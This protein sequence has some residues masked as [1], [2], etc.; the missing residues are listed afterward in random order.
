MA[1]LKHININSLFS[2]FRILGVGDPANALWACTGL[3]RLWGCVSMCTVFANVYV[4][5]CATC[6]GPCRALLLKGDEVAGFTGTLGRWARGG[7]RNWPPAEDA[8]VIPYGFSHASCFDTF[9]K[10]SGILWHRG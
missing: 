7:T 4:C 9:W 5:A 6:A 8:P 3:C 10:K 1:E 2:K